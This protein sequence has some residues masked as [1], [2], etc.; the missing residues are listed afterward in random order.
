[1]K[2][3]ETIA[4]I[5]LVAAILIVGGTLMYVEGKTEKATT[6][7]DFSNLTWTV[8]FEELHKTLSKE[9][10][11]TQWKMVDWDKLH[12]GYLPKI[13]AA[14]INNDFNAYYI[15]IRAY[16]NEIPD[17]HVRV[18]NIKEI[19]D[20]YIGGGFGLAIAEL[21]DGKIIVS[22]VDESGPAWAAGIRPGAELIS[23]DSQQAKGSG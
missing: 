8:A 2:N 23:W 17:G 13:V 18:D 14:Q 16:L 22:W 3:K 1:M 4:L 11:F 9:Y 19:D 15:A 6:D 20:Q 21:D 5:I 10:A 7:N 12:R